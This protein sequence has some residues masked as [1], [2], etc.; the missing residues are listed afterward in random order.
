MKQILSVL[1]LVLSL[2]LQAQTVTGTWYNVDDE[3]G[4]PKSHIEIYEEDGALKGKIIKLLP[5]AS[6]THCTKCKGD[7]KGEPLVGMVI[8]E[9]LQR[10][11]NKT[12]EDGEI[13]N[14]KNGKV[15]SCN[16]E[17]IEDDKLKV[18]G[19][20]GFSLLGKTQYWYRVK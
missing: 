6:G 20:L 10:E 2:S 3:D 17:L 13:L 14:P 8:L 4:K 16:V 19:F 15:Y 11:D 12:Y 1:A 7:K 9:G 18:R 5:A